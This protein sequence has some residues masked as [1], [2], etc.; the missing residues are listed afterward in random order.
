MHWVVDI[1]G[2]S[3]V[4][5]VSTTVCG[6]ISNLFYMLLI[7]AHFFGGWGSALACKY[8]VSGC[9][10]ALLL[11]FINGL[12]VAGA[13]LVPQPISKNKKAKQLGGMPR[14]RDPSQDGC[15]K[16]KSPC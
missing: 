3:T 2:L 6:A 7:G 13:E 4:S 16:N 11:F 14:A 10:P 9:I 5:T 15:Y 1:R 8:I 12:G